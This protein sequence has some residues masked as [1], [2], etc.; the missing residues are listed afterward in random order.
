MLGAVTHSSFRRSRHHCHAVVSAQLRSL[1]RLVRTWVFAVLGVA[2]IA[3]AFVYYSYIQDRMPDFDGTILPRFATP[4]FNSYILWFFM[5]AVVFVSFDARSQDE[6]ERIS[7]ALD[8]RPFSNLVLLGGRLLATVTAILVVLIATL[9]LIQI[10]AT[11]GRTMGWAGHPLEPVMAVMFLL[12]DGI[13]AVTLWGAIVLFLAVVLP[14]RLVV[15]VTA[16]AL[17]VLHMW[18]YALIPAYLLPAVSLHYIHDNWASD[19]APRLPEAATVVHRTSMLLLSAAFVA[20]A[21]ASYKRADGGSRGRRYLAG[22]VLAAVGVTGIAAVAARCVDQFQLRTTWL[23]AHEA[24]SGQATPMLRHIA[25]D[26]HINPGRELRLDLELQFE[27]PQEEDLAALVFSFNPGLRVMDLRL[28]DLATPFRHEFGL[29]TVEPT[30]PL[31]RGS[32]KSL[33]LRA[34]GMPDPDF[35]YLD[36]A[37]DWRA[38]SARNQ[39][40][41]LGTAA[42]IFERR[43]VALMPGLRWLPVP[44]PNLASASDSHFP[45]IDLAVDVPE[46]WL[47]AGP[48]RRVAGADGRF[49]FRPPAPVS[50]VGLLA[51]R[52]E[53]RMIE[54]AGVEFELLLHP[55][56]L[57]H[58]AVLADIVGPLRSRLASLVNEP[59]EFGIP[60]PYDGFSAVE[61]PSHL[62]AYGGGWRLDTVMEL[63][64]MLLLKEPGFPYVNYGRFGERAGPEMLAM[65]VE[66]GLSNHDNSTHVLRGLGRNL[67]P[68]QTAGSGPGSAALD[69]V[70]QKLGLALLGNPRLRVPIDGSFNAHARDVEAG[71]GATVT[72][73]MQ[74]LAIPA[75]PDWKGFRYSLDYSDPSVWQRVLGA[76]LT[77]MDMKR[78]PERAMEAFVLRGDAAAKAIVDS[79]GH[80]RTATLLATLRS[81]HGGAP[82][83]ADDFVAA[84]ADAGANLDLLL[85]DWLNESALPGFVVFTRPHRPGRRRRR[86]TSLRDA[87]PRSQ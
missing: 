27:T 31:V 34:T 56:H 51:A 30:V 75:S 13:P 16:L 15:A 2:V 62:R 24:A 61:V 12:V 21:A 11:V 18:C 17:L 55:G 53:R 9:L 3:T 50:Q 72:H 40:L 52:F 36:S 42:G 85:G 41:W 8:S 58:L 25:G 45:T 29:L 60:Y 48:G 1:R 54:V 49:L 14:N 86:R 28:N 67:V 47:V 35:A 39:I 82:Y 79:L 81:R 63:P 43:Y 73:V 57:E 19:L 6:R 64:G 44:G 26:V 84:A 69:H 59:A 46:G 4:Y 87:R 76:S 22:A 23:A 65:M 37:V 77:R 80:E 71:F 70:C 5:A 66:L 7:E 74:T 32:L 68:F 20:W 33:Q 10:S 78:D 83:D 38:E